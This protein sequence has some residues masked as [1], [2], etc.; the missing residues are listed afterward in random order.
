VVS[1]HPTAKD[2]YESVR[3]AV[4]E[5]GR[6]GREGNEAP[7]R[8]QG[9]LIAARPISLKRHEAR[10]IEVPLNKNGRAFLRDVARVRVDV[11]MSGPRTQIPDTLPLFI[12]R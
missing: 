10:T 9:R 5:V 7:S 11:Q 12:K 4:D 1:A 6:I 8:R 3:V 2:V